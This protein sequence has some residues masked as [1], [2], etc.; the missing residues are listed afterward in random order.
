MYIKV[1]LK[2]QNFAIG[3]LVD[4]YL[5]RNCGHRVGILSQ[6]NLQLISSNHKTF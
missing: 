1:S 6:C 3:N 5:K 2:R 4:K